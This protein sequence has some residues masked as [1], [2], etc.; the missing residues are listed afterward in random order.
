M[1]IIIRRPHA[2]KFRAEYGKA[3]IPGLVVLSPKGKML[4]GVALPSRGVVDKMVG[5]LKQKRPRSQRL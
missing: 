5:L 2:Y 3:S 4:G 1:R